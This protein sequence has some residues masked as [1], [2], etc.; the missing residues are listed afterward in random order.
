MLSRL[1]HRIR[2][3]A[4]SDRYDRQSN[5]GLYDLLVKDV[6]YAVKAR[7][8]SLIPAVPYDRFQVVHSDLPKKLWGIQDFR[9]CD[10]ESLGGGGFWRFS[11]N[12][13]D[14]DLPEW[15]FDGKTYAQESTRILDE[16]QHRFQQFQEID[17]RALLGIKGDQASKEAAD[18]GAMRIV[19]DECFAHVYFTLNHYRDIMV[20]KHQDA[21]NPWVLVLYDT[22]W[23]IW[24]PV[25]TDKAFTMTNITEAATGPSA[26]TKL[27]IGSQVLNVTLIRPKAVKRARR[28]SYIFNT[29]HWA[30]PV[31][32]VYVPPKTD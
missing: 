26:K 9:A 8:G 18:P 32:N 7:N 20:E 28:N 6:A 30:K 29:G 5:Y 2:M 31:K 27:K 1:R 19:V 12:N 10:A 25:S 23:G 13:E 4:M 14:G 16:T 11:H 3:Q 22:V 21:V 15:E 24:K 17:V